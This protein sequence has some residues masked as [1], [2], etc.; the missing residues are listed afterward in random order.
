MPTPTFKTSYIVKANL[1]FNTGQD[2]YVRFTDNVEEDNE[3]YPDAVKGS[4]L[5]KKIE[6]P[7][8]NCGATTVYC[9][10]HD[11]SS[12]PLKY[13]DTFIHFCTSCD[14]FKVEEGDIAHVGSEHRLQCEI[15]KRYFS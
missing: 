12:D 6:D 13:Q 10:Y 1:E 11:S 2:F 5:H 14:Y 8:P 3:N 9:G 7:C 4:G 15:C